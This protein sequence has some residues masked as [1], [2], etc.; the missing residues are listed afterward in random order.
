[1]STPQTLLRGSILLVD[2]DGAARAD[3]ARALADDGHEVVAVAIVDA[4]AALARRAYDVILADLR[5]P[6]AAG[7]RLLQQVGETAPEAALLLLADPAAAASAIAALAAGARDYF[8]RPAHIDEVR[9]RLRAA[10]EHRQLA[11]E[12]A[13]LGREVERHDAGDDIVSYSPAM[14]EVMQLVERIAAAP[15]AVLISGERG[16]GKEAVAR[17]IHRYG[18][19]RH[20]IF[21]AVDC[22][23]AAA[24][25]EAQ[26]FGRRDGSGHHVGLCERIR[27]GTIFLD[28]VADLPLA[29]QERLLRLIERQEVLASGAATPVRVDVRVIAATAR[30]L[31]REVDAGRL[32]DDLYDRLNVAG[33]EI[34]PLRERRDDVAPLVE[35]FVRRKNRALKTRFRGADAA[36]LAALTALPWPGNVRELAH[37]VE[38][39]MIAGSGEWITAADVSRGA[40]APAAGGD[41]LRQ[42]VRA[43]ERAHIVAVLARLQHDKR[44]AAELLG[45]SLSSLY[46]KLEELGI[47]LSP[48]RGRGA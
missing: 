27:H 3:L 18:D 25:L 26:L 43:Y 15:G 31:R 6:G 1:M 39:A 28:E 24:Q 2:D 38:Q 44:R 5:L 42:A 34:P 7:Q 45:V 17:A 48:D 29:V 14:R 22:D 11:W 4:D 16:V 36:A 47:P 40:A 8:L 35:H 19:R 10:L 33:I 21:L 37:A 23:A 46:R 30:D 9:H 41:D 20:A 32:R 13:H 12:R